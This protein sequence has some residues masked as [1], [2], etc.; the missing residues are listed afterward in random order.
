MVITRFRMLYRTDFA[1]H[2]KFSSF[3]VQEV[4]Q[5]CVTIGFSYLRHGRFWVKI[6]LT[7][8]AQRCLAKTRLKCFETAQHLVIAVPSK[9]GATISQTSGLATA[10]SYVGRVAMVTVEKD[11]CYFPHPLE[12]IIK[13]P[14]LQKRI[15]AIKT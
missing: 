5:N 4:S 13:G 6:I 3:P 10:C 1:T 14:C 9:Y 7:G 12:K 15:L 8:L 11:I 2:I